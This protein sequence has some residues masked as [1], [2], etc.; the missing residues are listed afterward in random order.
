MAATIYH[1]TSIYGHKLELDSEMDII[2]A[3]VT[4]NIH[5]KNVRVV[6]YHE[7][8][9]TKAYLFMF[10]FGHISEANL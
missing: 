7:R 5:E 1:L 9:P 4:C 8:T 6:V 2:I 10:H 3:L